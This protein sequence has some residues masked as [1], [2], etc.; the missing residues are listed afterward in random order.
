MEKGASAAGAAFKRARSMTEDEELSETSKKVA[1]QGPSG[2][3][4][5]N[6]SGIVV[7]VVGADGDV[8]EKKG[9]R[10]VEEEKEMEVEATGAVKDSE[11]DHYHH[12]DAAQALTS[13]A[14]NA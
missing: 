7:V 2:Q 14:Q 11:N 12:Q 8:A 10:S 5:D 1:D 9:L 13:L 6:S 3:S 4:Q